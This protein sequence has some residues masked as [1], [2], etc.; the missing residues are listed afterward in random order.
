MSL[1]TPRPD[2]TALVT[3]ASSG[4][5]VD[6]ARELARRGHGLVLVARREDRLRTL[7][8]ELRDA[9]GVRVE[10][11]AEDLGEL[12]GRDR[13]MDAISGFGLEVDV[14]INNAGFGVH[15]SFADADEERLRQMVELDVVAVQDL[16][17]RVLP[18]MVRRRSGAMLLVGSVVAFQP[19]PGFASYAASKAFV[20][21]LGEALHAE[22]GPQ[23]VTVTTL[24]PGPVRTE[25]FEV[26]GNAGTSS[27]GPGFAKTTPDVVARDAV[28][29]LEKG[30]RVV[31]PHPPIKAAVLGGRYAPRSILLPVLRRG[32]R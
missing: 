24:C 17:R 10:V 21:S 14:F 9:H 5:G 18:G 2:G 28:Q 19:V 13:T 15:G 26:A 27:E 30:R 7:A 25:F 32:M 22:L 8:D 20:L 12:S 29:G 23:G 1:P 4:I 11:V 6:V 3:G 16:A 31:V